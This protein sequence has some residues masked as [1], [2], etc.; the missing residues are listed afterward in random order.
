MLSRNSVSSLKLTPMTQTEAAALVDRMLGSYPSLTLHDPETYISVICTLLLG[1]PLWAAERAMTAATI[2]SKFAPPTPGILKPL[3][4]GEVRTARYVEEW[5]QGAERLRAL[6]P[7]PGPTPA[8]RRALM[9]AKREKYGP[10][11]GIDRKA[12]R[13][14]TPASVRAEIIAQIGQEAFDAIPDAGISCGD[15]AKLRAPKVTS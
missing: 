15:W 14:P 12:K 8:E 6:P 2:E 11:F 4:E 5:D 1:Y 10:G 7:P 13:E 3:L 9:A